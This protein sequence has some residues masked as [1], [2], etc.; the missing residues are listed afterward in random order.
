MT[1]P[2]ITLTH[3]QIMGNPNTKPHQRHKNEYRSE[4]PE[5]GSSKQ[6]LYWPEVG[7]YWCRGCNLSGF[8]DGATNLDPTRLAEIERERE[9]RNRA[10]RDRAATALERMKRLGPA[11]ATWYHDNLP[12]DKR[13]WLRDHYGMTDNEINRRGIGYRTP[14]TRMN[15]T[16]EAQ[17]VGSFT[18]PV[19]QDGEC[20][21]IQHRLDRDVGGKSRPEISNL[22][23][24]FITSITSTAK[25]PSCPSVKR[26][27]SR[28][29]SKQ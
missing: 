13:A 29:T 15:W 5:C 28:A 12:D 2:T 19:W 27:W 14:G 24:R 4:C 18:F 23:N 11:R 25:V 26:Y 17:A 21:Y 10:D 6:L 20:I 16:A 3:A 22:P 7:N 1:T 8:V 9:R